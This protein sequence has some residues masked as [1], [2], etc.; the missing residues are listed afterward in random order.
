MTVNSGCA[1]SKETPVDHDADTVDAAVDVLVSVLLIL[2]HRDCAADMSI[3]DRNEE[4]LERL[5]QHLWR[6]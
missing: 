6:R 1:S 5:G 4:R 3:A 2:E